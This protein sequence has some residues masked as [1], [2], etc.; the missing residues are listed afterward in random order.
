MSKKEKILAKLSEQRKNLKKINLSIVSDLQESINALNAFDIERDYDVAITDYEYALGLMEQAIQA[1][2]T[3]VESYSKFEEN[4]GFH[5]ERYAEA[6]QLLGEL[7]L[8]L[9]YLGVEPSGEI[10]S[11][12]NIV[13]ENESLAQDAFDKSQSDFGK[14]NDLVDISDFN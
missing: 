14:H 6:S 2:N 12:S 13:E 5:F 8:Q 7:E 10:E 3:Y 1:A 9:D 4:I 11:Y